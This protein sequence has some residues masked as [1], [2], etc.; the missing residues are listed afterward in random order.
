MFTDLICAA[1]AHV[2]SPQGE[3]PRRS[4]ARAARDAN[5]TYAISGDVQEA[6]SEIRITGQV[7]DVA[8]GNVLGGFKATGPA[9]Q[10]FSLL[11]DSVAAQVLRALPADLVLAPPQPATTTQGQAAQPQYRIYNQYTTYSP[12][13][14]SYPSSSYNDYST[15]PD[16]YDSTPYATIYPY[17]YSYPTYDYPAY[18]FYP[19]VGQR[20]PPPSKAASTT[21]WDMTASTMAC[22]GGF[23]HGFGGGFNHAASP[24]APGRRA[25]AGFQQRRRC[26][27]RGGHR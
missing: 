5:A 22:G 12:P 24:V 25:P 8:T 27:T 21:A 4:E 2:Q 7:T 11:E 16:V 18:G 19:S 17:Y 6:G 1:R 14:S 9:N 15:Q 20:L 23:V 13:A 3:P 26:R 10:L